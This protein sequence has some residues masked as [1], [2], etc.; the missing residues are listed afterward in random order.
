MGGT[1]LLAFPDP[2]AYTCVQA[3]RK[4][5]DAC[6]H[7]KCTTVPAILNSVNQHQERHWVGGSQQYKASEMAHPSPWKWASADTD[8]NS[9]VAPD[10]ANFQPKSVQNQNLYVTCPVK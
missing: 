9:P 8:Q 7:T 5:A 1:T 2:M 4:H 3:H 10:R 6:T